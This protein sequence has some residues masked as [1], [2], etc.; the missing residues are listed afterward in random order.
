V[1]FSAKLLTALA[2]IALLVV[3]AIGSSSTARATHESGTTH[4]N[5]AVYMTNKWSNLTTNANGF[6][7]TETAGAKE[8]YVGSGKT[9]YGTFKEQSSA[10]AQ[11]QQ[12]QTNADVVI[13]SIID[14]DKNLP[15][16]KTAT[17]THVQNTEG[18]QYNLGALGGASTVPIIDSDGDGNM[19]EEVVV[20]GATNTSASDWTV[21]VQNATSGIIQVFSAGSSNVNQVLTFTWKTSAVDTITGLLKVTS[22][23]DP[24]GITLNAVETGTNTGVFRAE[25]TLLDAEVSANA[26]TSTSPAKLKILNNGTVTATYEDKTP[27]GTTTLQATGTKIAATSKAET[28]MPQNVVSTPTNASATQDRRPAF[29]GTVTD[30]GSGIDVSQTLLYIDPDNEG[31]NTN[32][33]AVNIADSNSE[34]NKPNTGTAVDGASTISWSFTPAADIPTGISGDVDHIVDFQVKSTDLAGNIG[35]SDNDGDAADNVATPEVGT[36]T[37]GERSPA[38]RGAPHTVRI[39]RTLPSISTVSTGHYWDAATSAVKT[40]KNTSLEVE[41]DGPMDPA[42][43]DAADFEV[44]ISAVKYVPTDAVTNSKKAQSVFLTVGAEIPT[45]NKPTVTVKNQ[46]A[47]KAGNTTNSGSSAAV[48]KLAPVLTVVLSGGATSNPSG[49][50]KADMIATVTSTEALT[51]I[52]V[53]VHSATDAV[54]AE[55][56]VIPVYQ[57]SNLWTATLKGSSLAA[58]TQAG[59]KKS[60]YVSGTD[61]AGNAGTIGKKDDAA[62]GAILYTLDKV[63]PVLT[64]TPATTTRDPRPFVQLDFAEK[65]TVGAATFNTVDVAAGLASTDT[66]KYVHKPTADLVAG[67]QTVK[68]TAT[69]LAGNQAKD[70]TK[71]FT[72]KA[73]VNFKIPLLPGWNLVS[74]AS[75]P[76]D[77]SV[78][79]VI[80]SADVSTVVAYDAASGTFSSAVRDGA[81]LTGALA[82]MD[83]SQA[84]WVN[85]SSSDPIDVALAK[86]AGGTLPPAIPVVA[87][88]N[89][90]PVVDTSGAAAVGDAAAGTALSTKTTAQ[91]FS[92]TAVGGSATLARMYEFDTLN[93]KFKE[94]STTTGSLDL[95]KGYLAYF[96]QAGSIVP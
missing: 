41:F 64:T 55:S 72:A 25:V 40:G 17:S 63:A 48:D 9:L 89:A 66:Q 78:N 18:Q 15:A 69:D 79:S 11:Q 76:E 34:E 90:V 13:I 32:N 43:I 96:T 45:D 71:T 21:V 4:T 82:S 7:A 85:T 61:A 2:A 75:D 60:V 67:T 65:V 24:T 20:V 84:Y 77:S 10:G 46:I 26:S 28:S 16:T 30:S 91:Y 88:W 81:T 23:S 53:A 59:D 93:D 1:K 58:S 70:L 22:T 14:G 62:T 29:T 92:G 54:T 87:G 37:P 47:D 51:S 3:V 5:G 6:T 27:A 39:D 74:L 52:T 31:K 57:G 49:L 86:P 56:T 38:G 33:A 50:T 68:A 35:Y 19:N 36:A 12:I 44:S 42:S 73:K 83:S 94:V 80:T 8:T 95:G